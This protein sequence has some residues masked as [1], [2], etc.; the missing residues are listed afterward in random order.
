MPS[1]NKSSNE[2]MLSLYGSSHRSQ[3]ERCEGLTDSFTTQQIMIGPCL[4]VCDQKLQ[5]E[6]IDVKDENIRLE[7]TIV[8]NENGCSVKNNERCMKLPPSCRALKKSRIIYASSE[9]NLC[10]LL[11]IEDDRETTNSYETQHLK[12]TK[13]LSTSASAPSLVNLGSCHQNERHKICQREN[14][15]PEIYLREI[16]QQTT[17]ISLKN[18]AALDLDNFFL[19]I[20]QENIDAYN[21]DIISAVR[22]HD[23]DTIR[24]IFAD[25]RILQCCNRFGESIV[26]MACRRGALDVVRFMVEEAGVSLR[27]RDDYGRTPLHDACWT[28][29]PNTDLVKMVVLKCPDLLLI[30]DKRGFTPLSYARQDDWEVWCKFLNE[31]REILTPI[32]LLRRNFSV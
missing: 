7:Q 13:A 27:V 25:G 31:N 32:E 4:F 17:G 10:K 11:S 16:L 29:E 18:Y 1:S 3:N 8:C 6:E 21:D 20:S 30:S 22:R 15:S 14:L 26:H 9:V 24:Q 2:E 28:Q 23:V 12:T 19:E 5:P